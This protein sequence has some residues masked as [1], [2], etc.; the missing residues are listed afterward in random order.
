MRMGVIHAVR[1]RALSL[2]GPGV[3]NGNRRPGEERGEQR[4]RSE[5]AQ[6]AANAAV[7]QGHDGLGRQGPPQ[8]L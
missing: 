8:Q 1:G 3:V 6:M 5:A 2:A 7:I 4:V